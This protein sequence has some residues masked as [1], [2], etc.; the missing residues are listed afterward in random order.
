ML[1][2]Q[3]CKIE[4]TIK[5]YILTEFYKCNIGFSE[6]GKPFVFKMF[7]YVWISTILLKEKKGYFTHISAWRIGGRI[8][9]VEIKMHCWNC[10]RSRKISFPFFIAHKY[11]QLSSWKNSWII[12]YIYDH[13][14][15]WNSLLGSPF[16]FE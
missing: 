9:R 13:R 7:T 6:I 10:K 14:N 12:I 3:N 16:C 2:F 5:D 4:N 15:F 1:A 8:F 11:F